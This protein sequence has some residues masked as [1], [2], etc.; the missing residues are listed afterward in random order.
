[1]ENS[2]DAEELYYE[3]QYFLSDRNIEVSDEAD[4]ALGDTCSLILPAKEDE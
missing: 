2:M 3:L 4:Q 1:M